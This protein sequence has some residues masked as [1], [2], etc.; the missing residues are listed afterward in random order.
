MISGVGI[1][2]LTLSI[3]SFGFSYV[4]ALK[5]EKECVEG[6]ILLT[7]RIHTRIK[8][9]RQSLSEIYDGFSHPLL[10]SSGFTSL[11]KEKGLSEALDGSG[12]ALPIGHNVLLE[13]RRFASRLGKCF[14]EEQLTLCEGYLSF[15]KAQLETINDGL[16]K[17]TKLSISL[18][19]AV[20]ALSAILFI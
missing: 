10:D 5:S 2:L 11:L 7:E 20:S 19:C 14:Y 8:C 18:S 1:I 9:F 13:T 6:L 16:P 17:K 15:L 4:K 12:G 3:M